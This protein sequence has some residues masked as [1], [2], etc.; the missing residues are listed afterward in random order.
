MYIIQNYDENHTYNFYSIFYL[1]TGS[2]GFYF[3]INKAA[4]FGDHL[5]ERN[6]I[7]STDNDSLK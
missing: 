7:K 6:Y 3:I 4:F 1:Y 2:K 5:A